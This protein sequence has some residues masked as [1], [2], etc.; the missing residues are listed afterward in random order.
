MSK[1]RLHTPEFKAKVALAA[2]SSGK[3]LA[4]VAAD[5][6]LHP[7]QVCQWKRQ[8]SKNLPNIFRNP[9]SAGGNDSEED[10]RQQIS[11]LEQANATLTHELEWLKKKTL[12]LR[13]DDAA[14]ATGSRAPIYL[15]TA[16]M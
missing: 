1:R 13:S 11:K 5:H 8:A 9:D 10:L 2:L 3:T 15:F 7:V 12:Q 16:A 6:T 4:E 14:I